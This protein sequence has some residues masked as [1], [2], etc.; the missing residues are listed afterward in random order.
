MT[1]DV[2]DVMLGKGEQRA[3]H[4]GVYP[5]RRNV[6][7]ARIREPDPGIREYGARRF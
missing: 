5:A 1:P 6:G 7:P 4:R 3:E 2:D